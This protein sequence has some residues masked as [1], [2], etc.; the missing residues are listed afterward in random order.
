MSDQP[1]LWQRVSSKPILQPQ[2]RGLLS[3]AITTP[4]VLVWN[5]RLRLHVG[6]VSGGRERIATFPLEPAHLR[7]GLPISIPINPPV[8]ID[9]GPSRFDSK[10]VFDPASVVVDDQVYLYYTAIGPDGDS[11]GL[12]TSTDGISFHKREVPVLEGRAPEVIWCAGKFHIFYVQE[13][14]GKGYAVFSA[15]SENGE[16]F[17]PVSDKP[18]LDAGDQGA[19]DGFEVTT[20]RLFE[21]S[22]AF[23]MLYAGEGD[24]A[25]K[26]KPRAFGLARSYDLLAWERYPGNPVFCRGMPGQWD[27]GAIWFGT[28]FTWDDRLYLVYEGGT[29]ADIN[30]AGPALTQVGLAV[31]D[32]ATFERRVANW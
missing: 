27:D 11:L 28:V 10:H 2:R 14:P 17:S 31:V 3:E 16:A 15:T 5:G 9:T 6:A 12:A 18:I 4:D 23:Y 19:W 22:G 32:G 20:P 29:E 30:R 8:A 24:P 26:D 25:R 7:T 21:R 13:M 1:M